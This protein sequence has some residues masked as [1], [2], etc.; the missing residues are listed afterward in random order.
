MQREGLK[1]GF[2]C[3]SEVRNVESTL[4]LNLWNNTFLE[5]GLEVGGACVKYQKPEIWITSHT[6]YIVLKLLNCY[7][8]LFSKYFLNEPLEI[9]IVTNLASYLC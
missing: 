9:I 7:V 6:Q 5:A 3:R 1:K 2:E 4:P 8:K